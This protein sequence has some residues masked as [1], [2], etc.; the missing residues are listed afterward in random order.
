MK[1]VIHPLFSPG[2]RVVNHFPSRISF[3]SPS[4]LSDKDLYQYLQ[5]LNHTFGISQIY[6]NSAAVITDGSIKKSHVATAVAHIWSYNS[7]VKQF[8]V[9]SINI[10][11]I[12]AKLMA[13]HTGLIPAIEMNN[14]Y[15]II[16][17]TNSITAAKRILESKVN[18]L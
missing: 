1:F 13:I 10:T 17:I 5:N 2:S 16:V 6:S 8:Q 18:P 3:H 14:I 15:D 7:V 11:S 9:Q 4:S 12:E